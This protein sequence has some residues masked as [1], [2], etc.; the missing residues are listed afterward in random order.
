MTTTITASADLPIIRLQSIPFRQLSVWRSSSHVSL[1]T[2][3]EIDEESRK[4]LA[5]SLVSSSFHF[6][7]FL[8]SCS[9]SSFLPSLVPAYPIS[10]LHHSIPYRSF[11]PDFTPFNS[12]NLSKCNTSPSPPTS[13]SPS[14]PPWPHTRSTM[15]NWTTRPG[16]CWDCMRSVRQ[17]E[18]RIRRGCR[19]MG[20]P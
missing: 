5:S 15:T 6:S 4:G 14:T 7:L 20:V 12:Q 19:F 2:R 16:S 8:S 9:T 17:I 3:P 11:H 13:R 1:F 18:R 10:I